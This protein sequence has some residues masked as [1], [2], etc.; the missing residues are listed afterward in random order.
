MILEKLFAQA[1]QSRVFLLMVLGG[2]AEGLLLHLSGAL[3]R[4]SRPAG[5]LGDALALTLGALW[6]LGVLLRYGG[7]LRLYALLGLALGALGWSALAR[8]AAWRQKFSR[9]GRKPPVS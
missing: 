7:G 3:G 1:G 4:K 2:L 6:L 5:M 8:A 9:T